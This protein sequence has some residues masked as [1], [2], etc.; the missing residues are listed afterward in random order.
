MKKIW[1]T[2]EIQAIEYLKSK[3]YTILTTN[4]KYGRIGE[5]DII[6][7]H[8]DIT[9]F[10]EVKIRHTQ[11]YGTWIESITLSKRKKIFQTILSYM[12]LHT[13]SEENIRFDV[14]SIEENHIEHI[15]GFELFV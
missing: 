7:K 15:E 5:I 14:I 10:V 9:I 4:Y 1:D 12:E 3:W 2:W 11:S 6:A 13:I 8:E